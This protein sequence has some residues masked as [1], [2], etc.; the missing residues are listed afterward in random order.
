MFGK[1]SGINNLALKVSHSQNKLYKVGFPP[2]TW[3]YLNK[4]KYC[5]GVKSRFTLRVCVR[6]KLSF[7]IKVRVTSSFRASEMAS[8]EVASVKV[9]FIINLNF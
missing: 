9:D 6:F 5:F 8:V 4:F 1:H 7:S 2:K 3:C